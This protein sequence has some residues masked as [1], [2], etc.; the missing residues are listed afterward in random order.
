MR[1]QYQ[2]NNNNGVSRKVFGAT[3]AVG[4]IIIAGLGF[5][6]NGQSN[7]NKKL[8]AQLAGQDNVKTALTQKTK[9]DQNNQIKKYSASNLISLS[10]EAKNN[11]NGF[12]SAVYNWN[13]SNYKDRYN[14]TLK[15][16]TDST[17]NTMLGSKTNYTD[18]DF[19]K[20][21]TKNSGGQEIEESH[22]YMEKSDGKVVSG[23]YSVKVKTKS[24]GR[25]THSMQWFRFTY[26]VLDKKMT[27][28]APVQLDVKQKVDTSDED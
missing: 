21:V 9:A 12:F 18:Q 22:I 5:I 28:I 13:A 27:A 3:V 2:N 14:N 23:I 6:I 10:S 25:Y 16:A 19:I 15:Y 11:I 4:V 8:Q 24:N 1:N 7:A 20:N 26:N 17:T